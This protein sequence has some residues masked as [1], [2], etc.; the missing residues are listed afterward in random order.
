MTLL[1][2]QFLPLSKNIT[3]DQEDSEEIPECDLSDCM[4]YFASSYM[5]ETKKTEQY[6]DRQ[7]CQCEPWQ[8]WRGEDFKM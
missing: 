6:T 2:V 8:N 4:H 5:K 1:N 7:G 3:K